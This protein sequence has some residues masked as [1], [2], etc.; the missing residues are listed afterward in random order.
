MASY[1]WT[2]KDE[3]TPRKSYRLAV[4]LLNSRM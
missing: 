2:E 1:R 4:G 3:L